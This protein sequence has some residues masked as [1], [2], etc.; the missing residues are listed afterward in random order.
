M[1]RFE[2]L[3]NEVLFYTSLAWMIMGGSL[4]RGISGRFNKV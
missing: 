3:L 4:S 1:M 2:F